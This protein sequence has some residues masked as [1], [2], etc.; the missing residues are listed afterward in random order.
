[1]TLSEASGPSTPELRALLGSLKQ[2]DQGH[3]GPTKSA[4]VI[5][6]RSPMGTCAR[7]GRFLDGGIAVRGATYCIRCSGRCHLIGSEVRGVC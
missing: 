1:M 7:F 5:S 3:E 2:G 4:L 6:G